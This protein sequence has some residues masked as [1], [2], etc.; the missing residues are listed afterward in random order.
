MK[1]KLFTLLF[2]ATL[3]TCFSTIPA[4]AV[5]VG[6]DISSSYIIVGENFDVDVWVQ[7]AGGNLG[8]LTAFGFDV[9]FFGALTLFTY[10]GYTVDPDYDDIGWASY[11]GGL[12]NGLGNAGNTPVYLATLSFTAGSVAGTDTL[13]IDGLFDDWDHGLYYLNGDED[14]VS[15]LD[16]TI[17]PVPIPGAVWLLGSGLLGLVG[18]RRQKS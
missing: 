2:L 6:F 3:I 17:N 1:R 5:N 7:D 11:V 14:I 9:D 10:D 4:Q 18:L 12:Y 13:T 15:S 8:D 16:I